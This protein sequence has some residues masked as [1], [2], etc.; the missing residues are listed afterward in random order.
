M[1]QFEKLTHLVDKIVTIKNNNIYADIN[2]IINDINGIVYQI[3]NLTDDEI[4]E[5]K[6]QTVI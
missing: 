1:C 4:E 3:Y 5:I 2:S 6:S